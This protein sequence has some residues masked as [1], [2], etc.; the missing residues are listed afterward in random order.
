MV[1]NLSIYM[2]NAIRNNQISRPSHRNERKSLT[3]CKII[4]GEKFLYQ[5]AEGEA[6]ENSYWI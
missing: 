4:L 5:K 2:S 1:N 3:H 6:V